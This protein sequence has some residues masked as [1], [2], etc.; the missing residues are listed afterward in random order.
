MANVITS[1]IPKAGYL[2]WCGHPFTLE[3]DPKGGWKMLFVFPASAAA[4]ADAYEHGAQVPAAIF[5]ECLTRLKRLV[6]ERRGAAR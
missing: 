3:P 2:E 1:S 5:A 6:A 4:D